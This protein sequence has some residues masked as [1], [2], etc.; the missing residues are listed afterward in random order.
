MLL[1]GDYHTHT[2][3]SHG[4]NTVAENV[5]QAQKIGLQQIAITDHGFSHKAFGVKR[6]EIAACRKECIDA[7]KTYGVK[8]LLGLEA[9][10]RGYAG[11]TDMTE[12][13]YEHFDLFN[14][15]FHVFISCKPFSHR[16]GYFWGNLLSRKLFHHASKNLIERNTKAYI[17]G[18]KHNPI[19]I[20]THLSYVCPCNVLE[21][22]KCAADYGTYI[23]LNS[24]KTHLTDEQL[25]EI[26]QKTDARFV[27]NSDA[28]S[29]DRVG[30]TKIVDE[31]LARMQFPMDRID[32]IDGRT[33]HFRFA[34]YKKHL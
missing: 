30:D 10:I 24:K 1:T 18:I 9:N 29:S 17:E 7:E 22:A 28:H 32:N 13:D 2:P 14:C 20:L 31:Q 23:E 3:Y 26:V 8:V 16:Y 33:P 27:V 19:D 12:A 15:G 11:V 25:Y 5:A 4:K 21:V 34:A 6:K